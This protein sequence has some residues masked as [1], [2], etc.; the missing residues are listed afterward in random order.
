MNSQEGAPKRRRGRPTN[1]ARSSVARRDRLVAKTAYTLI[2]F[3]FNTRSVFAAVAVAL[4]EVGRRLGPDRTEQIFKEWKQTPYERGSD[5]S[6]PLVVYSR[7]RYTKQSLRDHVPATARRLFPQWPKASLAELTTA[8]RAIAEVGGEWPPDP[9][10]IPGDLELAPA[11][12]GLADA[13]A[14]SG[15]SFLARRKSGVEK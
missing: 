9:D 6:G 5:I 2:M 10:I 3:G 15:L 12:Q 8:A 14:N 4:G 13:M 11:A 7:A 1:R